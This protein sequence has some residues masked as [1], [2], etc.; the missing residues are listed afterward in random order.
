MSEIAHTDAHYARVGIYNAAL[1]NLIRRSKA[2]APTD[3]QPVPQAQSLFW[4]SYHQAQ[5]DLR[6][7]D[8]EHCFH[9]V[10]MTVTVTHVHD[11]KFKTFVNF[12]GV[13]RRIVARGANFLFCVQI[14]RN[15]LGEAVDADKD[16]ADLNRRSLHFLDKD[17]RGLLACKTTHIRHL[18]YAADTPPPQ[19]DQGPAKKPRVDGQ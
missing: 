19:V 13:I 12:E 8:K 15:A 7:A 18:P 6:W 9:R 2:L 3:A 17:Q 4:A 14:Q 11:K 10:G 1:W 16:I 5:A